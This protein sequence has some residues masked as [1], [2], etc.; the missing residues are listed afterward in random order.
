MTPLEKKQK[1]ISKI[2]EMPDDLL[3]DVYNLMESL[4]NKKE[5]ASTDDFEKY[6]KETTEKYRKVWEA[7]A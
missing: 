6:L 2:Q 7:L 1:I 4:A 3:D 5:E